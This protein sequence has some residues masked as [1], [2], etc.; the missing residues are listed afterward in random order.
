MHAAT[1]KYLNN[2]MSKGNFLEYGNVMKNKQKTLTTLK[3]TVIETMMT[4]A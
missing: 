1:M 4:K 2:E 3:E